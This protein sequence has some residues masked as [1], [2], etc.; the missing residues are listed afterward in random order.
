MAGEWI[1]HVQATYQ[2]NKRNN[3]SYLYKQAMKD[4]KKTFKS[5]GSV[6]NSTK[7][8]KGKE[9]KTKRRRRR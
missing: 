5:T 4:A 8:R 9:S 1:K 7:R 6:S 3:P 2:A